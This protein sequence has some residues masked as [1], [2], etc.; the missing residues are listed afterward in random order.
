[1]RLTRGRIS[2][3]TFSRKVQLIATFFLIVATS[4]RVIACISPWPRIGLS[5]YIVCMLGARSR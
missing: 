5:R 2:A 4:S 1:M 3:R